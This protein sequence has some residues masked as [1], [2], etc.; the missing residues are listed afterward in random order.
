MEARRAAR[1]G[2]GRARWWRRGGG[3]ARGATDTESGVGVILYVDWLSD[4]HL[5]CLYTGRDAIYRY[6]QYG[7]DS[8]P[9]AL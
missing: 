8:T 5:H 6:L 3:R 9:H 4:S 2:E 1:R 7:M